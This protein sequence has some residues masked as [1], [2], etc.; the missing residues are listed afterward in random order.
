MFYPLFITKNTKM[1]PH[2]ENFLVFKADLVNFPT[3]C[4]K[5]TTAQTLAHVANISIF[6]SYSGETPD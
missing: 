5:I 6:S 4:G 2:K 3:S 1:G